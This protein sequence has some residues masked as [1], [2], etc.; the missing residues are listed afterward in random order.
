MHEQNHNFRSS[1]FTGENKLNY[2][3]IAELKDEQTRRT[4]SPNPSCIWTQD[5]VVPLALA[6]A[7][8]AVLRQRA[9]AKLPAPD[10]GLAGAGVADEVAGRRARRAGRRWRTACGPR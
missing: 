1:L 9:R 8:V 10:R 5:D 4:S 2:N 6:G 3:V 7:V